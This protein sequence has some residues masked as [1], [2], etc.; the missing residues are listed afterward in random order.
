MELFVKSKLRE[1]LKGCSGIRSE[2]WQGESLHAETL[3][4]PRSCGLF[5]TCPEPFQAGDESTSIFSF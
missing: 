5:G 4:F 2:E 3:N 1:Q